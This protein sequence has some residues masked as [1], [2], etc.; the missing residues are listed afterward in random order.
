MG[1]SSESS[2]A[3]APVHA[4]MRLPKVEGL[5]VWESLHKDVFLEKLGD[6]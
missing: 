3:W 5:H 6:D 4:R 1:F 2:G